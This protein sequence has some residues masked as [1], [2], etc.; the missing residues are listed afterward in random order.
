MKIDLETGEPA[1]PTQADASFEYF[2]AEF[3]PKPPER[4]VRAGSSDDED[5]EIKPIDLF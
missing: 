3:V 2:L 4:A 5:E 1:E